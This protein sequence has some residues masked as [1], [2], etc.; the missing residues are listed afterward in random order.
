MT[1]CLKKRLPLAALWAKACQFHGFDEVPASILALPLSSFRFVLLL[2][3]IFLEEAKKNILSELL[4]TGPPRRSAGR[5]PRRSKGCSK[6][7][8]FRTGASSFVLPKQHRKFTSASSFKKKTHK[9]TKNVNVQFLVPKIVFELKKWRWYKLKK[10]SNVFKTL[11]LTAPKK[12]R[13]A[14][15]VPSK[16]SRW[17][18]TS[19]SRKVTPAVAWL[20]LN[21]ILGGAQKIG[22]L[23]K[24]RWEKRICLDKCWA[25]FLG[26]K[27]YFGFKFSFKNEYR[28]YFGYLCGGSKWRH[29]EMRTLR[30]RSQVNQCSMIFCC[31]RFWDASLSRKW[32]FRTVGEAEFRESTLLGG[33]LW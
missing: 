7:P 24:K 19:P 18:R 1:G 30:A 33:L 22:K 21:P 26:L 15:W 20:Q 31:N 12:K 13:P 4:C 23:T 9:T 27:F 11:M 16:S 28:K 32:A 29:P 8:P 14:R 6:R 25:D 17:S 10:K 2:F 3:F 5:S